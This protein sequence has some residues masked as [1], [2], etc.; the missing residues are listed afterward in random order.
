MS[1]LQRQKGMFS[2]N[3]LE[4]IKDMKVLVAGAGGLGTHQVVE[5]QRIGI[6]KIYL[7]DYDRIEESNLNRQTLYGR[8]N[9]GQYKVEKAKEML[10]SFQLDTEIITIRKKITEDFQIP[11]DV[12]LVFDAVDNHTTRVLLGKK[13]IENKIPFIHGAVHSWYGQIATVNPDNGERLLE[14]LDINKNREEEIPVFSPVVSMIASLQVI[15]GIKVFLDYDN[16]LQ[17]KMMFINTKCLETTTID[18]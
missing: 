7:V 5:L 18:L 6:G 13:G 9:L 4:Q 3:E 10:D 8:N 1:F 12:D 17:G 16:T 14:I 15:E 11:D 2:G